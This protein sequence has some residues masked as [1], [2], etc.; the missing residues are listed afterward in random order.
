MSVNK[1]TVS[2]MTLG[3]VQLGMNYGLIGNS[4]MPDV[5]ASHGIL[6]AA[7]QGGVSAY[8]TAATYGESEQI[9]GRFFGKLQSGEAPTII[10]KIYVQ[11]EKSWSPVRIKDEIYR[12]T[13]ASLEKL[14]VEQ[15]SA[16]M[17]HN[18]DAMRAHGDIIAQVF[19]ELVRDGL[20]EKAGISFSSNTEEEFAMLRPYL[21][22]SVF[23]AVQLPLNVFDHRPLNN[24]CLEMLRS[25]GKT[26]FVRSVF[27]QG[28]FYA[29]E[30]ELPSQ[31]PEAVEPIRQLRELAHSC[32]LTPAELAVSYIRDM[33]G[34]DSLVIGVQTV[35]QL[36]ENLRLIEGPAVPESICNEIRERF[37]NLPER[38]LT[39]GMWS[40]A[41]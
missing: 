19:S 25:A 18:V 16:M 20:T 11:P 5:R 37:R 1:L 26:V 6:Q 22:D 29:N 33:P 4:Q 32:G 7:W 24:G 27:L 12:Q 3:T 41:R 14:G 23:G 38:L 40:R 30:A 21:E 15:V 13:R 34:V 10:T 35:E 8:D 39:P 28:L 2:K 17:L 9:L 31:L 36:E